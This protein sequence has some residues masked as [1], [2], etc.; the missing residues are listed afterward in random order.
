MKN[1]L[2]SVIIPCYNHGIYLEETLQSVITS[3][4]KYSVEIIIVNDGSTDQKTIE[5]F[6]KIEKDGYKIIHQSNQGL[7]KARNNGIKA[8]NGE[9]IL[10]LDSDNNITFHYLN[11]AIDLLEQDNTIE[12]VYG[13]ARYFGDA[14]GIWK[15]N[16][17]DI[18]KMLFINHIDA[19]A[20]FR[21]T[22][23]EKVDGYSEDMPYM[24]L[25]DWNFWLKC[26]NNKLRFFYLNEVCFEYRVLPNSMLRKASQNN[27]TGAAVFAYNASKF[28]NLYFSSMKDDH[29]MFNNIFSG[30]VFKKVIKLILN[31]FNKYSYKTSKN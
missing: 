1:T 15:N 6:Q 31:H 22:T 25:E 27:D 2:V 3:T 24:G 29:E 8:S 17:I 9:Y 28:H 26:I 7:A 14:T 21:R 10:P 5:I 12:I 20:V 16:T 23:W 19:C 13:D 18:R 11:T 4:K 30:G